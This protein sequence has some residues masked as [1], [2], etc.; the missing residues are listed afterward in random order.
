MAVSKPDPR[1]GNLYSLEPEDLDNI[2]R[3]CHGNQESMDIA[4]TLFNSQR[5]TNTGIGYAGVIRQFKVFCQ[6]QK[7][8]SYENFGTKEVFGF[9]IQSYKV[10][11][12]K[13]FISY[14]KPAINTIETARGITREDSVFSN[15]TIRA[16][17]AGAKRRAA[18]DAPLVK[19]MDELPLDCLKKGLMKHIWS[20]SVDEINF[21][22]FRTLYRWMV[23]GFTLVRFEGYR[24]V[25]AKH[26]NIVTDKEGKRAVSILFIKDKNDQVHNGS[27][28]MLPEQQGEIIEPLTLTLLFFQKAGFTLGKGEDFLNCR[29]RGMN[30]SKANGR[31]PLSYTTALEDGKKVARELGFADVKYG[32]TSAKRLGASNARQNNVSLDTIAHV[33]GWRN[34]SMVERYLANSVDTKMQHARDLKFK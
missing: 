25:Q 9:I 32:E 33:G 4:L 10:G 24:H 15:D 22:V 29:S 17:L 12:G 20:K 28:R 27:T 16:V 23:M 11:K 19:K 26:V 7:D 2:S 3:L 34:K 5:A 14:I 6:E 18:E 8:F 30:G 1:K 31:F 21:V 13:N